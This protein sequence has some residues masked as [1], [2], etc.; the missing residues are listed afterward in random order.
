MSSQQSPRRTSANTHERNVSPSLGDP[1]AFNLF[2]GSLT[3][4]TEVITIMNLYLFYYFYIITT[5]LT[6]YIVFRE[7]F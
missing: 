2:L 5:N 6:M 1:N 4:E 7:I 3:N